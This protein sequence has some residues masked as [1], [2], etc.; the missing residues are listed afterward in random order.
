MFDIMVLFGFMLIMFGTIATQL[1][2][3]I[4]E[5]RCYAKN[6]RGSD[7]LTYLLGKQKEEIFCNTNADCIR[8]VPKE[9][10][11][12]NEA[13]C[14]VMGNPNGGTFAFDDILLSIM[15]IF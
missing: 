3:G 6:R 12:R 10:F 8:K 7:P 2:G 1:F 9:V 14:Q 13:V 5:K 15:N 4:L 11:G